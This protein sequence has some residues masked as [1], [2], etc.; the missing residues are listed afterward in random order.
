M[1]LTSAHPAVYLF[2]LCKQTTT[3]L[4]L[5]HP[6]P[7]VLKQPP[8]SLSLAGLSIKSG[9]GRWALWAPFIFSLQGFGKTAQGLR[10]LLSRIL[11]LSPKSLAAVIIKIT[12]KG[13]RHRHREAWNGHLSG[14][15]AA[16]DPALEQTLSQAGA[17]PATDFLPET[18]CP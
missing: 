7:R 3:L 15:N 6:Q 14:T 1:L 11:F 2:Y 16:C 17:V 4:C 18:K 5:N 9:H 8:S 13:T 12:Q 10:G